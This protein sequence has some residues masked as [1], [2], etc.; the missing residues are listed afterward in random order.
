MTRPKTDYE[1]IEADPAQRAALRKEELI[2][3]A[4]CAISEELERQGV[5]KAELAR[6]LGRT[7][8][9]VTQL[10]GGRNLTLGS[11]AEMADALGC[12]VEVSVT[13]TKRSAA[14]KS[15]KRP[16]RRSAV[17]R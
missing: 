14:V 1:R 12:R 5:N 8:G 16:A 17:K 13:S 3:A 10:L 6:R 7:R 4:T 2:L 9:H 15:I 11:L